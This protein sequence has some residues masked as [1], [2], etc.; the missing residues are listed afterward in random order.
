MPR[1]IIIDCDPGIDD[2]LALS[3]ALFDP[4]LEVLAITAC[5]GTVDSE[6]A[7]RNVHALVERLDPPL[8]PRIGA[9]LDPQQGAAV[10]NGSNLHGEHGLGT[11]A[12]QPITRQHSIPS[13]KLLCDQMRAHPG[14]ITLVC[15]GPLTGVAQALSRDPAICTLVDRIIIAGGSVRLEGNVSA[16]AE[17]NMHFDPISAQAVFGSPT[18][19]TLL[20]LEVTSELSFGWELVDRLP[21]KHTRIGAVL[22]EV[23]PHLFR[24]TRQR[25]G[26]E[27]VA[28]QA[29]APIL[30]LLDPLLFQT[31]VMAGD[32]ET[33]GELTRGATIF[34]N[35]DPRQWLDNM[36]VA[37]SVDAESAMDA[38]DNL[39]KYLAQDHPS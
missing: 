12:W 37:I 32:V 19:K 17:F 23:V 18:S 28:F 16:C 39:L 11:V 8:M 13:D 22:H 2:A 10:S 27:T 4:R 25:L 21:P 20:P 36:E 3:C 35:R 30:M 6:Q 7:T 38:F 29:L 9:A 5:A 34:D 26:R 33:A 31:S 15:T 24:S 14:E 1:K